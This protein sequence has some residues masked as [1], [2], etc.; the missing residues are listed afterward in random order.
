MESLEDRGEVGTPSISDAEALF[1]AGDGLVAIISDLEATYTRQAGVRYR[2]LRSAARAAL[3]C[4]AES[5]G[6]SPSVADEMIAEAFPDETLAEVY[7]RALRVLGL[8]G[9]VVARWKPHGWNRIQDDV[10]ALVGD[11]GLLMPDAQRKTDSID[12][13][14]ESF[15]GLYIAAWSRAP[16]TASG[17]P[18]QSAIAQSF[19]PPI[20]DRTLRTYIDSYGT[21]KG[22][23]PVRRRRAAG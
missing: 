11:A 23:E 2:A 5:V 13:A 18:T 8:P 16:K 14:R 4:I 9:V 10:L 17:H 22:Y 12:P 19:D 7:R 21:P 1:A 6:W 15:H 20:T 3:E